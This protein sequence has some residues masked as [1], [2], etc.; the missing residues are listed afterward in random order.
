M[1][2][3]EAITQAVDKYR[4]E[5][6]SVTLR[7]DSTTLPAELRDR[8]PALVANKN[9]T[10]VLVEV[11][12][13][14]RLNDLPPTLLPAG[15]RFDVVMLP[16]PDYQDAPGP[17]VEATPEFAER[18]LTELDELVPKGAIRARFLLAWSAA[19]AAMRVA[20]RREG[21]ADAVLSPRLLARDLVTAG[22][23]SQQQLAQ[24]EPVQ[25]VR[26]RLAHGL[27]TNDLETGHIEFLTGFARS[28]LRSPIAAA[29]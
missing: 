19:E 10:S 5:G 20:A 21:I 1:T 24:L 7:P 15:W 12:T 23:I 2:E 16:A 14:G 18:L 17:G 22:V 8:R 25:A 26:N 28:L 9:G 3:E 27:P 6:Y 4:N 13:R 29:G 11:W